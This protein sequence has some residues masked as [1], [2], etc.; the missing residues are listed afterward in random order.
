VIIP[1]TI[2]RIWRETP[3]VLSFSLDLRS[4]EFSFKAG[5]WLDC[6][7]GKDASPGVAGYTITSRPPQDGR[8]QITVKYSQTNPVTR[9]LH[10]EA[11]VG[12][13]IYIEGGQGDF[14]YDR[15][16]GS[17][18]VLL[19]DDIGITPMMS[20]I[21]Y[22]DALAPGVEVALLYSASRPDELVFHREL[23]A[24]SRRNPNIRCHFTV[25]DS[26]QRNWAGNVGAIDMGLLL[27]SEVDAGSLYY[28]CG[29]QPHIPCMTVIL[30]YLGVTHDRILS[31]DWS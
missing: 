23:E 16:M 11:C 7:L 1:V 24:I 17:S 15:S 8:I 10:A 6:Y 30:N 27:R 19:A 31:E 25:K 18:L 21:R 4:Q 13:E 22:V 9:Y 2:E 5:Q 29:P 26:S 28:V 12:D 3:T 20:I 14:Y